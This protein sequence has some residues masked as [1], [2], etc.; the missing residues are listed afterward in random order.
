MFV[1]L[2]SFFLGVLKT[3]EILYGQDCGSHLYSYLEN[4]SE[5][6]EGEKSALGVINAS[7]K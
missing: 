7:L 6:T 1:L 5:R 2:S 3:T 4:S